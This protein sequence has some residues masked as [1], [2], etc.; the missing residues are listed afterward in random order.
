[1]SK[2]KV[3]II[4]TGSISNLHMLGYNELP[5]VEVYAA[6]DLNE[7]RVKAFG[8]KY[9]IRH[10]F[11]DYNEM[12]KMEELDAVSVCAWN[13]AHAPAS[14]A[15]LKAGKN[16]LCEKPLAMSTEEALEMKKAADA[17]GKLLMVGFVRRFGK[18][19]RIMKDFINSGAM[20]D[21]YYIKTSCTRRCGNPGGWF[22]DKKRSGGGPLIDLGVHMIDLS[23]FLLGKPKSV[24]VSGAA[25]YHLGPRTNIKAITRYVPADPDDYCDVEDLAVAFIRFENGAVLSVECSFSQHIH[26]D[27]LTLE[28]YGTKSGG[29]FEPTIEIASEMNDYL[30]D[31]KPVYT[32]DYDIFSA[33]FKSETAHFIDCIVNGTQCQNPVEDGVE[34]MKLLDAVYESARTGK[35][36]IL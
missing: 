33:N 21:I 2:V 14:I 35:E 11:T 28:L 22:S 18:N 30:V 13:N 26:E 29:T 16:V 12:L 6:C 36:V 4:G 32:P 9:G 8:E 10:T 1:M 31:I 25:F 15:A 23:W 34:I 5:N 3:G 17:S 7:E 20:G 24:S 27:K 19:T